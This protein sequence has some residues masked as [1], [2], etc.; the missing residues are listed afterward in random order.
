[1]KQR[2]LFIWLVLVVWLVYLVF[3]LLTPQA[4]SATRYHLTDT[5]V[6]IIKVTF[7]LPFLLC[8]LFALS[9]WLHFR[10]YIRKQ[11]EGLEHKGF[12]MIARGL[13]VLLIGLIVP[14]VAS[15]IY[16]YFNNSSTQGAAWT[17]INNYINIA[18]PFA[19]FLL[20][21]L[22]SIQLMKQLKLRAATW[23]KVLT[24]LVPVVLFSIFY[25]ALIFTNPGRQTSPDPT[26]PA[27][28]FVSDTLIIIT[29][30]L[31]VVITWGMGL[32]LALNL[33]QFSHHTA[34]SHKPA[35]ITLYNGVLVIVG[36]AI[37]SQALSSLG[38]SRF[39]SLNL[40]FI[41]LLVY[42]LLGVIGLGYALIARG[43]KKLALA[44]SQVPAGQF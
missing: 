9:G 37:L 21:F 33:E 10:A 32:L 4:A 25:V 42:L 38:G 41:L 28:Y 30:I 26:I 3:S 1:M 15:T 43:A 17:I 44:D 11:S 5:V 29:I 24:V 35:L 18:F 19:G 12:A 34:I 40:G 20:M 27:T 22:G 2:R 23:S 8:W 16:A 14:T 7:A 39:S 36:A 31:P 6:N 13:Y